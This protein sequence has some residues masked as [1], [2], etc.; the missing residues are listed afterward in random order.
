[1]LS[2]LPSFNALVA[3]E[4]TARLKSVT[5]AANELCVTPGAVSR[6]ITTLESWMDHL[7]M[8]RSPQGVVLTER[9]KKLALSLGNSFNM[10]AKAVRE[11][12]GQDKNPVITMN[13]YPTFAIQWLMPRL[14]EFHAIFPN[15]DLRIKTSLQPPDFNREDID[16][17]V[18]ISDVYPKGLTGITLVERVFSP[19]CS[20][21]VLE[22]HPGVDPRDV[23]QKEKLLLSGMH[24]EIWQ[25]W[26]RLIDIPDNILKSSVRFGNSSLAWQA[27]RSG[28]GF[29]MGQEAL[30]G[31]YL[32]DTRLVAPFEETIID[33]R[34]Y[35]LV[36]RESEKDIPLIRSLFSWFESEK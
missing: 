17:A 23:L 20:P 26:L 9:G 27:A 33:E 18:I 31:T 22:R 14:A 7:L 4:A 13:T 10:I 32:N 15:V 5:E 19:V 3:F 25:N 35:R 29:A 8:R 1:M 34:F 6:Q 11:A 21:A 2:N 16:I 12:M 36:C 24:M 28:A 30:L